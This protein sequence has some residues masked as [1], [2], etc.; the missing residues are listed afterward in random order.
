MGYTWPQAEG[1]ERFSEREQEGACYLLL[2]R[3]T[4]VLRKQMKPD[5]G[6]GYHFLT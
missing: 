5:D 1:G 6:F 2:G 3:W 4:H